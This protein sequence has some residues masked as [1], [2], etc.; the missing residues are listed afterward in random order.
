[1][2][3]FDIDDILAEFWDEDVDELQRAKDLGV[4]RFIFWFDN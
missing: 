2:N 3:D 1:M 4:E